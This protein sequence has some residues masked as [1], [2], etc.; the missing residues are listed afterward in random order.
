MDIE[1]DEQPAVII[2]DSAEDLSGLDI[3]VDLKHR[4][5]FVNT[6]IIV[7]STTREKSAILSAGADLYLPKPYE[8]SDLIHWIEKLI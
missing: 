4:L 3:C 2:L 8:I 7:T 6:K 5:N 1:D